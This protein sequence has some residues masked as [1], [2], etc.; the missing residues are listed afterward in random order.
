MQAKLTLRVDEAL[1]R[2]AKLLAKKRGTSVSG[3]FGD[4]ISKQTEDLP[5]EELPTVT[6]SMLGVLNQAD[7]SS[8]ESDYRQHLEE[9]YL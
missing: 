7:A 2:K 5:S 9:R 4:Y 3:I 1:V 6:A 8:S